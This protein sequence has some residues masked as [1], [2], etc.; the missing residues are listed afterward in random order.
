MKKAQVR[1]F[2]L[3]FLFLISAQ[4]VFAEISLDGAKKYLQGQIKGSYLVYV[5]TEDRQIL[6]GQVLKARLDFDF[7]DGSSTGI[8]G[9]SFLKTNEGFKKFDIDSDLI[10]SSEFLKALNPKFKL[11][12]DKD[13]EAFC[14]LLYQ[15]TERSEEKVFKEKNKLCFVIDTFFDEV[16]Y[17]EVTIKSTGKILGIK[18]I[19]K[20]M[21][22]PSS[23]NE[24][25]LDYIQTKDANK[26]DA[27]K[28]EQYLKKI[29]PDMS[30]DVLELKLNKIKNSVKLYDVRFTVTVKD[31]YGSSSNITEFALIK[32]NNKYEIIDSTDNIFENQNIKREVISK[33]TIKTE[34]DA[35]VFEKFLDGIKAADKFKKKHFKEGSVWCF[36]RE[37]KFGDLTGFLVTVDKTGKILNIEKSDEID[38]DE[39]AQAEETAENMPLDYAFT[40]VHPASDEITAKRGEEVPVEIS[41]NANAVNASGAYILIIVDGFEDGMLVDSNMQSPLK[42]EI[43]IDYLASKYGNV[44]HIIEEYGKGVHIVEY[45]LVVDNEPFEIIK[46]KVTIK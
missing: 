22:L 8:T 16:E 6:N 40:L 18:F 4:I 45:V 30:F 17:Y 29:M 23:T 25:N 19:K 34:K 36:V 11:K 38:S 5:D 46:I 20:E 3:L 44:E 15:I 7:G 14:Y 31:E 28:M 9:A 42:S 27:K 43:S 2:C 41:F 39:I 33:Y 24:Y 13:I 37:E 1:F 26:A 21:K 32:Y 10:C 35:V 12:T